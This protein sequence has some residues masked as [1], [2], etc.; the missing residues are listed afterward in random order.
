MAQ[1][2]MSVLA[3]ILYTPLLKIPLLLGNAALTHH[4]LTPPSNPPTMTKEWSREDTLRDFMSKAGGTH[5]I[6]KACCA[7]T[8]V[9]PSS[10]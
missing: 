6:V 10:V 3:P 7:L 8:K 4:G 5:G 1:R 9:S 2:A